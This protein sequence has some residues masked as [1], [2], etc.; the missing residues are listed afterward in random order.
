MPM[1]R[2]Y[3]GNAGVAFKVAPTS[4]RYHFD[5]KQPA[6]R[7]LKRMKSQNYSADPG[8]TSLNKDECLQIHAASSVCDGRLNVRW[9]C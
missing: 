8:K 7:H 4:K 9:M 5:E 2:W 3:S 6:R 1:D